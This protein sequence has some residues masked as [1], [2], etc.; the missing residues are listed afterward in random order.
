MAGEFLLRL[1][2]FDMSLE[3]ENTI[4][5]ASYVFYMCVDL[6]LVSSATGHALGA[7][8][9]ILAACTTALLAEAGTLV[10]G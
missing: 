6:L 3:N 5:I 8:D 4:L 10:F 1:A 2:R 7:L 9:N